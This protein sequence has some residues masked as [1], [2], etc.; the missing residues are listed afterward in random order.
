M[1]RNFLNRN[2]VAHRPR[3]DTQS[4]RSGNTSALLLGLCV[5]CEAKYRRY[6]QKRPVSKKGLFKEH[7]YLTAEHRH[8]RYQVWIDGTR[9]GI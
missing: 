9:G 2:S 5:H 1:R 3:S 6:K 4:L 8:T 7:I